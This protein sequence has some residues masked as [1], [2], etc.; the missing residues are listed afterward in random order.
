MTDEASL[1]SKFFLL[2]NE[3]G[4]LSIPVSHAVHMEILSFWSDAYNITNVVGIST[5]I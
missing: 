4:L 1:I 5:E 3:K 2:H